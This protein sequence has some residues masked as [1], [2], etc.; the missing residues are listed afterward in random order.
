MGQRV[1][2][3]GSRNH[4]GQAKHQIWIQRYCP[5]EHGGPADNIFTVII[6]IGDNG[7]HR[8]LAAGA[9]CGRDYINWGCVLRRLLKTNPGLGLTVSFCHKG[10]H[11]GCIY[12]RAT[13]NSQHRGRISRLQ[14]LRTLSDMGKGGIWLNTVIPVEAHTFCGQ[15]G[16]RAVSQS[17]LSQGTVR[18]HKHIPMATL[19]DSTAEVAGTARSN[20]S[21]VG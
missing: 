10:D 14:C 15:W 11:F 3:G 17:Q 5:R 8:R 21:K 6:L 16:N 4:W 12:G 1:H 2:T 9:R 19:G 13:P 7:A 18:D 20:K